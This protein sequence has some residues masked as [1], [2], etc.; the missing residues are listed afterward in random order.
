M[1]LASATGLQGPAAPPPAHSSHQQ[2]QHQPQQ[3]YPVQPQ[4]QQRVATEVATQRVGNAQQHAVAAAAAALHGGR[5]PSLRVRI[6]RVA[7]SSFLFFCPHTYAG[8]C[9]FAPHHHTC[10]TGVAA[11]DYLCL[12]VFYLSC[13]A[14]VRLSVCLARIVSLLLGSGLSVLQGLNRFAPQA[15]CP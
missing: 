1:R 11:N 9:L 14:H 13:K 3:Q 15:L 6:H 8:Q 12:V 5:R 2:Q 10:T 7:M 4:Q